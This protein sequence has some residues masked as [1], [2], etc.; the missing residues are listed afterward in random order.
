MSKDLSTVQH[1][2][3]FGMRNLLLEAELAKLEAAGIE[4]G[5]VAT[6]QRH[7][8]VDVELFDRDI[9]TEAERMAE[10]YVL[11]YC[12]EN[13]VR[14]LISERLQ[15]KYGPAWWKTAVPQ[16][17]QTAVTDKQ[18]K[19]KDS[20][21]SIRSDD[22][23]T[24]TNFGE[25]ISIIEANWKA[26]SDTIRSKKAMQQTLSQFNQIR[27]V[28]AHSCSLSATDISRLK[29]LTTDWLNIQT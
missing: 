28:I 10:L 7:E 24:Y 14:R 23:L 17:I 2:Q 4:M 21:L 3:L 16:G 22:P 13:T 8:V 15:E 1:M 25:L 20:V 11:Y 9:R 12:L 5:H 29:L 18:A 26:F 6:L 27:N 19:E